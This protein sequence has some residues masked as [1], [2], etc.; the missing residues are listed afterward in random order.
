[1]LPRTGS[2]AHLIIGT[3]LAVSTA[4]LT[5]A[6]PAFAIRSSDCPVEGIEIYLE[7]RGFDPTDLVA[8]LDPI[9]HQ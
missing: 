7:I 2:L 4:L 1:M 3:V 8:V 6:N 9:P 5:R